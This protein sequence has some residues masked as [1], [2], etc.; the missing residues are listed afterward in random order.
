MTHDRRPPRVPRAQRLHRERDPRVRRSVAAA[1]CAAVLA[2]VLG[3]GIAAL[4]IHQ[5]QLAYRLEALRAERVQTERLIE[6]LR[7]EAAT[8]R[9][10]ARLESHARRLGLVPPT[11]EQVRLAREYV[12]TVTSRST[13][14]RLERP[15]R[16]EALVR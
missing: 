2:V 4:R 7:V 8:L 16:P 15:E 5:V 12:P 11:R 1:V 6:Q 10:P 13:A 14:A 3:L 9:T